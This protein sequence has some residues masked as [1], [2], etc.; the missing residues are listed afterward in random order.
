[1]EYVL[2]STLPT[3]T[4]KDVFAVRKGFLGKQIT[5]LGFTVHTLYKHSG[6]VSH[7]T[8]QQTVDIGSAVKCLEKLHGVVSVLVPETQCQMIK[9]HLSLFHATTNNYPYQVISQYTTGTTTKYINVQI[10]WDVG[11]SPIASRMVI[12][13]NI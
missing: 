2:T 9:S 11:V 13:E 1:M 5:N 12:S 6:G 4:K 10:T 7:I 3:V 8:L